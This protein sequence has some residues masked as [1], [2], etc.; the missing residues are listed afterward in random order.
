MNKELLSNLRSLTG[1]GM[2]DCQLALTE[3][4]YDLQKAIDIIKAKNLNVAD[5]RMGRAALEGLVVIN[6]TD[7]NLMTMMEINCQTDF[8]AK[9]PT[10]IEFAN[11]S[12]QTLYKAVKDDQDFQVSDIEGARKALVAS[13]KENVVVRR[14]WAEQA[15]TK[16]TRV[17]S[18]LHHNKIGVLLTMSTTPSALDDSR[19]VEL[20]ENI[21][22][23]IAAMN[24]LSID[25][26]RLSAEEVARQ[27]AIFEQQLS[28]LNKPVA[29]WPKILE[30]KFNKWHQSVCL[31]NQEAVWLNKTSIQKAI[32]DVATATGIS[33]KVINFI[34][35]EVGEGLTTVPKE[36]FAD[37][38]NKLT[39][40]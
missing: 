23:Q 39:G 10:F 21:A 27:K 36:N 16:L 9:S 18:Y 30:G 29:A 34:R 31:L 13:T 12:A 38:V 40:V 35:C 11:M 14:W 3:S 19:F 22:M 1:A 37:E 24:P 6:N 26:D 4:N 28:E 8:V 20:G 5:E 17:F 15:F 7:Y 32:S 25:V 2:N 33:I